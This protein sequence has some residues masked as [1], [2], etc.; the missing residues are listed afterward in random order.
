MTTT[1]RQEVE[2]KSSFVP[3]LNFIRTSSKIRECI[4]IPVCRKGAFCSYP[5][6]LASER[7]AQLEVRSLVNT[8]R[9]AVGE[10]PKHPATYHLRYPD[11]R[12]RYS[13]R[14]SV[15]PP[16]HHSIVWQSSLHTCMHVHLGAAGRAVGLQ[17]REILG[18]I[19]ASLDRR[20]DSF[21]ASAIQ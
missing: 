18:R 11:R 8:F 14:S 5:S 3:Y 21:K 20:F 13:K 1:R 12:Y 16:S 6:I 7:K 19:D 9:Q 2:S 15:A 17:R 4:A 10:R